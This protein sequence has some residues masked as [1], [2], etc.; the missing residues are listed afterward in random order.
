[1]VEKYL[2]I[3][4][5][6]V[7]LVVTFNGAIFLQHL[8]SGIFGII[9]GIITFWLMFYLALPIE[10]TLNMLLLSIL[11]SFLVGYI[12]AR[13]SIGQL[14]DYLEKIIGGVSLSIIGLMVQELVQTKS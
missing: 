4:L 6:I 10:I 14:D 11:L 2:G 5:I 8:V 1:M 9:P 12:T 7:G 13:L 3:L